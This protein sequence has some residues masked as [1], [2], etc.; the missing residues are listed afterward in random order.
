MSGSNFRLAVPREV[1]RPEG[2]ATGDDGRPAATVGGSTL[3]IG[4]KLG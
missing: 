3:A 1:E 4:D 2:P